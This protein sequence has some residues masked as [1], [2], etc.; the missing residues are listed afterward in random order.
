[1]EDQKANELDLLLGFPVGT[2][3]GMKLG[4]Q[5][6]SKIGMELVALLVESEGKPVGLL[7]G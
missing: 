4:S 1:M 7:L 2:A 3:L 5:L 6:G